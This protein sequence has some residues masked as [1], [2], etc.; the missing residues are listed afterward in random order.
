MSSEHPAHESSGAHL[1][2][3]RIDGARR[4]FFAPVFSWECFV[5]C[6]LFS[7]AKA[8]ESRPF[9]LHESL[10]PCCSSRSE[11]RLRS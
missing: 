1:G 6:S 10:A 2:K 11:N 8:A 7:L 9:E 3:R 5:F 4:V